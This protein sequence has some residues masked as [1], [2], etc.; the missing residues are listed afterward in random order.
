MA[1]SQNNQVWDPAVAGRNKHTPLAL[2]HAL[3]N[4]PTAVSSAAEINAVAME[5]G[6][7]GGPV[8]AQEQAGPMTVNVLFNGRTAS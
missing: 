7:G 5:R 4:S 8:D 6:G 1:G 2:P 3:Q